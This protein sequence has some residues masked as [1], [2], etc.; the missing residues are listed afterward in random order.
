MIGNIFFYAGP[1]AL[2]G[3]SETL[4]RLGPLLRVIQA[5]LALTFLVHF[6]FTIILFIQ[7][8]KARGQRYSVYHAV[9]KHSAKYMVY[10]GPIILAYLV[11][12][13]LDYSLIHRES[14]Y[15]LVQG[16]DLG[17]YGLVFNSFTVG[18]IGIVRTLAYIIAMVAVGSHLTH[19]IQSFIQTMGIGY[20]KYSPA[21]KR[22]S[23][24]LGVLISLI[25]C[26]IPIYLNIVAFA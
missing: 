5:G 10:T 15:S 6:V 4:H 11:F 14:V 22:F 13:L 21:I 17:L 26:S 24:I 8:R 20:S 19:A 7:N 16:E 3:Y 1:E 23:V 12:H 25:F 18:Q 9:G 2:N